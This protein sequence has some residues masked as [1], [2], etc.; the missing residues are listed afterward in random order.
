MLEG[1]KQAKASDKKGLY[2]TNITLE[3]NK[4]KKE[5]ISLTEN[6]ARIKVLSMSLTNYNSQEENVSIIAVL[7]VEA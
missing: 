5:N 2:K 3:I 6:T 4:S 7:E 1:W